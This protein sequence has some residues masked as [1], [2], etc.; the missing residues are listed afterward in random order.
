MISGTSKKL[1]LYSL[2]FINFLQPSKS[3]ELLEINRNINNRNTQLSRS[4]IFNE[5]ISSNFFKTYLKKDFVNDIFYEK[6][7]KKY[8]EPYLLANSKN[9]RELIIQSDKQSEIN[10]VIYAE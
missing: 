3:D 6:F 7:L 4:N 8:I 9:Q 1:I 2:F 10:D 5:E